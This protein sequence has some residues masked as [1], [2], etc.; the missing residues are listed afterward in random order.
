MLGLL[1]LLFYPSGHQLWTFLLVIWDSER[2]PA[3]WSIPWPPE[4][5][6]PFCTITPPPLIFSQNICPLEIVLFIYLW[7]CLL[8][9]VN[10]LTM[11]NVRRALRRQWRLGEKIFTCWHFLPC[12]CS[13]LLAT[14]ISQ[15]PGDFLQVSL[16]IGLQTKSPNPASQ[17]E[18]N[19]QAQTHSP[20]SH[21]ATSSEK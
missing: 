11:W 19:N 5:H 14:W 8:G 4:P 16:Q 15:V 3:L 18:P 21:K 7:I 13:S 17:L 6:R 20:T 1:H 2:S 10:D 9:C 12:V